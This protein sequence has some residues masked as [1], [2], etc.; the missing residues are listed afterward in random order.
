M[1][2]CSRRTTTAVCRLAGQARDE[3]T[4][5]LRL[6]L[7]NGASIDLDL[8]AITA[9]AAPQTAASDALDTDAER[10][11]FLGAM[12]VDELDEDGR[13]GYNIDPSLRTPKVSSNALVS[14]VTNLSA[15]YVSQL[16]QGPL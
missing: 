7:T 1:H 12:E 6:T 3:K 4:A 15:Q 14:F 16:Q 13:V 11:D 2:T 10:N 5:H 8:A 9:A